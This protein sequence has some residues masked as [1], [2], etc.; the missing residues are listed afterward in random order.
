MLTHDDFRCHCLLRIWGYPV[1]N[2]LVL[3]WDSEELL[4]MGLLDSSKPITILIVGVMMAV[5]RLEAH[6][7]ENNRQEAP[8]KEQVKEVDCL[9]DLDLFE[10]MCKISDGSEKNMGQKMIDAMA[11]SQHDCLAVRLCQK[12]YVGA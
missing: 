5:R 4:S 3:I 1:R 6:V 12:A 8:S 11:Q 2:N 10:K 9:N 7:T